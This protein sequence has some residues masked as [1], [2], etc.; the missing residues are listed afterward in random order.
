MQLCHAPGSLIVFNNCYQPIKIDFISKI[1]EKVKENEYECR[2][3]T[4]FS[5]TMRPGETLNFDRTFI[6]LRYYKEN[7][8]YLYEPQLG[9]KVTLCPEIEKKPYQWGK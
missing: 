5:Y 2:Y 6:L 9:E 8:I 4:V 3:E 7:E 1:K